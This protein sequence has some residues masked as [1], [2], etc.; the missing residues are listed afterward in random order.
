MFWMVIRN[1]LWYYILV[2]NQRN[3]IGL[4]AA[5]LSKNWKQFFLDTYVYFQ[6]ADISILLK[7]Y[8][9][10][11]FLP[12]TFCGSFYPMVSKKYTT[13]QYMCLAFSIME[14]RRLGD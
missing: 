6:F 10:E 13:D 7:N 2:G 11:W 14:V 12:P 3:M 5:I 1:V 4:R 9:L 8:F